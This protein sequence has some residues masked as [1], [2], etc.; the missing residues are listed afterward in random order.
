[1]ITMRVLPK[2]G[3]GLILT[4]ERPTAFYN[5][6]IHTIMK[7][8]GIYW[9]NMALYFLLPII[10]SVLISASMMEEK[11]DMG[12][13]QFGVPQRNIA[14]PILMFITIPFLLMIKKS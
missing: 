13:F 1:M 4:G 7:A 14:S 9:Q 10:S 12:G 6:T 8:P 11:M 5:T 3:E 2:M